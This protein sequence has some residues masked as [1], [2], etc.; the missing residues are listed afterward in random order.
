MD[1]FEARWQD[2]AGGNRAH[3]SLAC[4]NIIQDQ[5]DT[6]CE[7]QGLPAAEGVDPRVL[8]LCP[9]RDWGG[10]DV[11]PGDG[12]RFVA[13]VREVQ[14]VGSGFECDENPRLLGECVGGVRDVDPG[15]DVVDRVLQ[16]DAE[17]VHRPCHEE[18]DGFGVYCGLS[19]GAVGEEDQADN[20]VVSEAAVDDIFEG[21]LV[22]LQPKGGAEEGLSSHGYDFHRLG[23]V[24]QSAECQEEGP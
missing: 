7:E 8:H 6:V 16:G 13:D 20:V 21:V 22:A 19:C 1:N 17:E 23:L 15:C 14:D 5:R 24:R 4:Q 12:E 10:Q 2:G 11:E 18:I 9:V 3:I